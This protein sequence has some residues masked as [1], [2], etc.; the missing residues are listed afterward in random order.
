MG[1]EISRA[2]LDQFSSFFSK[3]PGSINSPT[4]LTKSLSTAKRI[5]KGLEPPATLVRELAVDYLRVV[6][7]GDGLAL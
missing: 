4:S 2:S 7:L 6:M 1:Y 5:R 3:Q